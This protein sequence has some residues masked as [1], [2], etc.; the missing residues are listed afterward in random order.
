MQYW[1]KWLEMSKLPL[2]KQNIY[3]IPEYLNFK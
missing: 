1:S 2:I 3:V